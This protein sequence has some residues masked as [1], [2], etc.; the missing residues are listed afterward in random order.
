MNSR[1]EGRK[2]GR[3]EERKEVSRIG[4]RVQE[5]KSARTQI[6]FS[7]RAFHSIEFFTSEIVD[8]LHVL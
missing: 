8:E 1:K 2:E 5:K 7:P 6:D 3:K 4:L